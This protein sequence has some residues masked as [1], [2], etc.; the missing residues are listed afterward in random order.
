MHACI[1]VA[2]TRAHLTPCIYPLIGAQ[3]PTYHS[4][5]WGLSIGENVPAYLR[6]A[7]LSNLFIL[8]V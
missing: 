3:A 4:S 7:L 5:L 2:T 6:H 8:V 1:K